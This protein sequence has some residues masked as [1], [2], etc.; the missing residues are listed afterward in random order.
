M[1]PLTT[2]AQVSKKEQGQYRISFTLAKQ[3]HDLDDTES[4]TLGI[5]AIYSELNGRGDIRANA[6]KRVAP[7]R[8]ED[9]W[10]QRVSDLQPLIRQTELLFE[11]HEGYFNTIKQYTLDLDAELDFFYTAEIGEKLT[12]EQAQAELVKRAADRQ[13][14]LEWQREQS[15]KAAVEKE[16]KDAKKR[17]DRASRKGWAT[18]LVV[19]EDT[20]SL[21]GHSYSYSYINGNVKSDVFQDARNYGFNGESLQNLRTSVARSA[22]R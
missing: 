12:V 7:Y 4:L 3:L 1:K 11:C 15:E 2:I 5:E 14:A 9:H 18:T 19:T 20:I 6:F 13:R 16:E 22:L 21:L 8:T 10:Y 17:A